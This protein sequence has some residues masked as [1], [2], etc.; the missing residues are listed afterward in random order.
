MEST[1]TTSD[2]TNAPA[3]V[4]ENKLPPE[5]V[6]P[7]NHHEELADLFNIGAENNTEAKPA[8]DPIT[9]MLAP[10]MK[11]TRK[12]MPRL[13]PIERNTAISRCLS[14][15]NITSPDTILSAA[16]SKISVRMRNMTLR[17][18]S[19][20]PASVRLD[21]FQSTKE[22]SSPAAFCKSPDK[23]PPCQDHP[24]SVRWRP[25]AHFH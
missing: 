17:S 6:G 21:C 8:S 14:R 7:G 23:L 25:I 5:T 22:T 13:A 4:Q 2:I 9:P 11:N 10:V 12:T 1:C 16:T 24:A 18:T 19:S 3:C 20:A 15:T